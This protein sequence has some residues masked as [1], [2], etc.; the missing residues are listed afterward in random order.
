MLN[1]KLLTTDYY[2]LKLKLYK[3]NFIPCAKGSFVP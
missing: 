3:S 2:N 1:I